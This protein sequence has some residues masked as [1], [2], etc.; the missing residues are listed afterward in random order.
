[1][2]WYKLAF[3]TVQL[4]A[5]HEMALLYKAM[6]LYCGQCEWTRSCAARG[7][8]QVRWGCER[9]SQIYKIFRI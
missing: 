6:H 7:H 4:Q 9:G 5:A 8:W 2:L 3:I 1:M